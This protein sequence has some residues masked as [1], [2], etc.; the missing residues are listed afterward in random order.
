[1]RLAELK[2]TLDCTLYSPL[3][4]ANELKETTKQAEMACAPIRENKEEK[5]VKDIIEHHL[6]Q[7]LGEPK[8]VVYVTLH[9]LFFL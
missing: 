8:F 9:L 7:T 3:H 4:F 5:L 1:M 2:K 6:K